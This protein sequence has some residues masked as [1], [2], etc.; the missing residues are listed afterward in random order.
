MVVSQSISP[1]ATLAAKAM[2]S[3]T[4]Y[5]LPETMYLSPFQYCSSPVT[6]L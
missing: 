5:M 2:F 1:L 3:G 6:V 4:L